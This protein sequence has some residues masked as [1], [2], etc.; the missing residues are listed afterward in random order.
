MIYTAIGAM[1]GLCFDIL[2]NKLDIDPPTNR[3]RLT[4]FIAWP[5][6]LFMFIYGLY[7]DDDE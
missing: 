3:E 5:F 7:G 6:F 1:C 2:F 4:W